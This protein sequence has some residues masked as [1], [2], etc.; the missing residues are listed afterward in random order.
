MSA[1]ETGCWAR[2]YA[3]LGWRVFPVTP[4]GKKPVYK[5]WQADATTDPV[6]IEQYWRRDPSPNIGIVTGES[7]VA[8]DI[9]AQHLDGLRSWMGAHGH[10]LPET[11]IAR[12]GRGGIHVLARAPSIEGGSDLY[13]EGSHVGE[14]KAQGGFIVAAPSVTTGIYGWLRGPGPVADAPRWLLTLRDRPARPIRRTPARVRSAGDGRRRLDALAAAVIGIGPGKRNKYLYWAVRRAIE[15]GVP[16][17]LAASVLR[18]SA[19]RAGLTPREIDATIGS[20][21]DKK[22]TE[23]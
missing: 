21:I 23:P 3:E 4:G 6:L 1:A 5:G 9:E 7:F 15:E 22:G 8:F 20:A 2:T 17:T 16:E 18:R 12:T 13:I 19:S 11:P 14:L 10:R